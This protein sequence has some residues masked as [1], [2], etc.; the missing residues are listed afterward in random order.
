MWIK[1]LQNPDTAFS[2]TWTGEGFWMFEFRGIL[3]AADWQTL[4]VVGRTWRLL[5]RTPTNKLEDGPANLKAFRGRPKELK[6]RFAG[7]RV[8]YYNFGHYAK[9]GTQAARDAWV[10]T[11]EKQ[12]TEGARPSGPE[13]QDP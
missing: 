4:Q 8:Y 11:A 2:G 10:S 7:F 6:L 9:A 1:H 13:R 3:V 5:I 12:A